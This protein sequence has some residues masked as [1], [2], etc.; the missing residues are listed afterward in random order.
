MRPVRLENTITVADRF[1][2]RSFRPGE[3]IA[4]LIRHQ[5][6]GQT[7]QRIALLE[8]V[9]QP[10]YL[11]WLVH[12]NVEGANIHFS[13][14][15]LRPHSRK[16]TKDAIETVRHLYLDLD[17]DGE[18]RLAALQASDQVPT[19]NAI[20]ATSAG[21][22]Q[23]LWRVEGFTCEQQE[24]ALK[25][26]ALA[27]GGDPACTDCS[28]VLRLPGFLNWKYAPPFLVWVKYLSN[29]TSTPDHFRLDIPIC[30]PTP[31]ARPAVGQRPSHKGTNS[32]NDWAWVLAE[33]A[34]GA[35]A[36][37]LTRALAL[38]RPDKPNPFYYAL[39]TVDVASA[40]L[41]LTG[42]IR[43]EDVI[44]MLERRRSAAIPA[45]L[46]RARVREIAHT[47]ERMVARGKLLDRRASARSK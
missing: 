45:A 34:H 43:M 47:A 12:E 18:S 7:V 27:F 39:R 44:T 4:V 31:G 20:V 17:H 13:A 37:E 35:D 2:T 24:V 41:W 30:E 28:R 1:L 33:L 5:A 3:T 21:K 46:G 14:N 6:P 10:H 36:E 32:E 25:I 42:G 22:Y 23:V 19:P 8:R 40:K 9:L 15:P 38:R 26:L 29:A 16:R 11:G